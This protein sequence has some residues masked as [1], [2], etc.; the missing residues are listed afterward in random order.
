MRRVMRKDNGKT[1]AVLS[2]S[3][4]LD[5]SVFDHVVVHVVYRGNTVQVGVGHGTTI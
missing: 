2:A 4:Y 1:I 5:S 3:I